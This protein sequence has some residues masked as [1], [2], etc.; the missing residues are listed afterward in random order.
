[1]KNCAVEIA[2]ASP[3]IICSNK[4]DSCAALINDGVENN[5]NL[6]N[7]LKELPREKLELIVVGLPNQCQMSGIILK[8]AKEILKK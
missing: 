6:Y 7:A 4:G 3:E 8:I 2:L 5:D 1:M